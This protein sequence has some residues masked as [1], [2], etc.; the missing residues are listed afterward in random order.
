MNPEVFGEYHLMSPTTDDTMAYYQ[1]VTLTMQLDTQ[2]RSLFLRP[3]LCICIGK[4]TSMWLLRQCLCNTSA[5]PCIRAQALPPPSA[6]SRAAEAIAHHLREAAAQLG[7]DPDA[8]PEQIKAARAKAGQ[9]NLRAA[10]LTARVH[11]LYRST[12]SG[13]WALTTS[14]EKAAR[15]KGFVQS[16]DAAS[17]PVGLTFKVKLFITLLRYYI[18]FR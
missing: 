12:R 11:Y 14:L 5:P 6:E 13:A 10:A 4:Y 7:F 15:H 18:S 1:Q 3:G 2:C 8:S 9:A 17:S 16:I